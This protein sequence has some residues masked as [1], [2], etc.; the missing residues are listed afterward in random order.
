MTIPGTNQPRHP[1]TFDLH[2]RQGARGFPGAPCRF[3]STGK[4]PNRTADTRLSGE[5]NSVV[6]PA[7]KLRATARPAAKTSASPNGGSESSPYN[8]S[9]SISRTNGLHRDRCEC[10]RRRKAIARYRQSGPPPGWPNR[11]GHPSRQGSSVRSHRRCSRQNKRPDPRR[12]WAGS[13]CDFGENSAGVGPPRRCP[14]SGNQDRQKRSRLAR[15]PERSR[16]RIQEAMLAR[17]RRV[18]RTAWGTV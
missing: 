9:K 17:Q 7:S 15:G 1:A 12:E 4:C 16:M 14:P 10:V 3:A 6:S 13:T 2:K 8:A 5:F 18:G 11:P